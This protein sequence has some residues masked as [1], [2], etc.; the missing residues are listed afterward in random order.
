VMQRKSIWEATSPALITA[1]VL[2]L[3]TVGI[4]RVLAT[5]GVTGDIWTNIAQVPRAVVIGWAG[6]LVCSR[7]AGGI[8]RA[9]FGGVIALFV[10]HPIATTITFLFMALF[11]DGSNTF[12]A[13]GGA[14][15]S[16]LMFM[17]L[18]FAIGVVGGVAAQ[19]LAKRHAPDYLPS[20]PNES[21][22]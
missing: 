17:P 12:M 8:L 20:A 14:V 4:G 15:V 13:I 19:Y 10:D 2:A 16:F 1:F 22:R 18:A 9:G 6:W 21:R 11:G 3:T 7:N 5:W